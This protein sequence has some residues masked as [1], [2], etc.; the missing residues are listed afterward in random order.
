MSQ[1]YQYYIYTKTSNGI[2]LYYHGFEN[3]PPFY[4]GDT[5]SSLFNEAMLFDDYESCLRR[6]QH[7]IDKD[8]FIGTTQNLL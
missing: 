5:Y 8:T 6:K 7:L 4:V 1:P 2:I 3:D